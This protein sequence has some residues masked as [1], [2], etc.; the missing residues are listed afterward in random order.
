MFTLYECSATN[1]I[2]RYGLFF[3]L[4]LLSLCQLYLNIHG[5][6]SD[7]LQ[8][9]LRYLIFNKPLQ[10]FVL[11]AKSRSYCKYLLN[12]AFLFAS[13]HEKP[14]LCSAKAKSKAI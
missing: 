10:R 13:H 14:Y 3:E 5:Y 2:Q 7:M 12:R 9:Y 6:A 1:K 11:N 4:S 8:P